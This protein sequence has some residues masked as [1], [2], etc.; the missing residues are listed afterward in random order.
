MFMFIFDCRVP[1]LKAARNLPKP[2]TKIT[3]LDNG[4]RVATEETY[5]QVSSLGAFLDAG[6][7]YERSK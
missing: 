7:V 1:A 5:G 6:S 2:E 3:T 4:V